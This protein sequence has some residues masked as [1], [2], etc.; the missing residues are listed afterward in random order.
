MWT[1]GG[2][3]ELPSWDESEAQ[4]VKI[5]GNLQVLNDININAKCNNLVHTIINKID[6]CKLRIREIKIAVEP[7]RIKRGI[8]NFVGNGLKFFF[9]NMDSTDADRIEK[10]FKNLNNQNEAT[11]HFLDKQISLVK[12]SFD[13]LQKPVKEIETVQR[14]ITEFVKRNNGIIEGLLNN[15]VKRIDNNEHSTKI[16]EV[17]E[18]IN[19]I[20]ATLTDFIQ[21][22][23]SLGQHKL[24]I[25]L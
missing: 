10:D 7:R 1:V 25:T 19:I 21:I 9:G 17:S 20:Q 6:S 13:L 18:S 22:M 16:L 23:N 3:I 2:V 24:S 14:N 11:I 8:A 4:L 5:E 12:D 15:Q